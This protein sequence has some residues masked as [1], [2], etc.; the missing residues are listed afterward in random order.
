MDPL[1]PIVPVS[2]DITAVAPPPSV[3][4]IERDARQ[5]PRRDPNREQG[6]DRKPG[7]DEHDDGH[8]DIIA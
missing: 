1:H 4:R 3:R 5:P 6:R 7:A 2:P 8:V